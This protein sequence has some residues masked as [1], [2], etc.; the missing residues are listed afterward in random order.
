MSD[1]LMMNSP[2]SIVFDDFLIRPLIESD[3]E[4]FYGFIFNNKSRIA[5]SAPNTVKSVTD[6]ESARTFIRKRIE[7]AELRELFSYTLFDNKTTLPVASMVIMNIDVT[8]PK[9]EIGYYVDGAYEGKGITTKFVGHI[10]DYAFSRL[11]FNKLFMRIRETNT[12]SRRVAEKNNF[13]REGL[14][15]RDFRTYEDELVD[16]IYYGKLKG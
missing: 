1:P 9:G 13:Q 5:S 7:L 16:V 6:A 2:V 11:G 8:V 10:C 12:G 14:L 4:N 15:R 3:A